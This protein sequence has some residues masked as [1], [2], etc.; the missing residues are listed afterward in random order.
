MDIL[1]Y[2]TD[3]KPIK[4]REYGR[5]V[6]NMVDYCMTLEDREE[7][8]ACAYTVADIMAS[9]F[10]ELVG[11]N[12]DYSTI[13]DHIN[14]LSDFKLDIDF[15]CEVITSEKM[16]PVPEKIPYTASEMRYRHYGKNIEKMIAVVA[17][18]ED[19]KDKD[20]LISLLAHHMKKLL[21]IHNKEGVS[22]AKVLKD[23]EI[24]SHGKIRLDPATYLLHEF[25]EEKQSATP[26]Q[27]KKKR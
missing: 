25:K 4:L 27:K 10:P 13:W 17:D 19:G 7:R 18:M 12:N 15:P 23:L 2:N 24:Y 22:D 11:E 26:K 16:N 8:T 9:M 21:M 6:Q 3:S 1:P 14:M 20:E 5:N